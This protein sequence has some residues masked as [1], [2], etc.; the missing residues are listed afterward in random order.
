MTDVKFFHPRVHL[1]LTCQVDEGDPGDFLSR[2]PRLDVCESLGEDDG[3][4]GVRPGGLVVHVGRRHRPVL[5]A[6]H[7]Q[8][9]DLTEGGDGQLRET[10]SGH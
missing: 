2:D 6:F 3:E 1:N 8:L 5:V 4:D 9:V 7:H 10:R